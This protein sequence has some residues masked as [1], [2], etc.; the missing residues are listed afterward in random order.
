MRYTIISLL[1]QMGLIN[2]IEAGD[3]L[4]ALKK[5]QSQQIDLIISDLN[6]PFQNGL[7]ILK[8]VRSDER[9]KH[10]PF[11]MVTGESD[12]KAVIQAAKMGVTAF[13][14]KPF[15]PDILRKKIESLLQ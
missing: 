4:Q 5:I 3:G 12:K 11:I 14:V 7:E 8:Y 6:M 1:N 10:I 2:C 13:I 9:L 15:S